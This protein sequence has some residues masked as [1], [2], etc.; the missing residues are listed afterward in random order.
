[1]PVHPVDEPVDDAAGDQL[2]V[3]D[4][5]QHDRIDESGAGDRRGANQRHHIPERGTETAS[6]RRSTSVSVVTPSDW[7]W[8]FVSTRC[9]STG[10]AI[11]RTSRRRRWWP[12]AV[13]ALPWAP[14]TR[15]GAARTLAP[16]APPFL[17]FGGHEGDFGG[18]ARPR[19]GA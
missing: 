12:P 8:K 19:L 15:N 4:A 3:A 14:S 7:A 10:S 6:R 18:R 11:A 17:T 5:R 16:T 1:R 9:R 13:G 2:E